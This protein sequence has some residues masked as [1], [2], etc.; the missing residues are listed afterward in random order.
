MK[1]LIV[2]GAVILS[3]GLAGTA[4]AAVI[5]WDTISNSS[6]TADACANGVG[7]ACTFTKGTE[8]LTARAYAT[9][10]NAGSGAFEK[11]TITVYSGGIGVKNPDQIGRSY[12]NNENDSPDHAI[13]NDGRDDLVVFEFS[14]SLFDPDSFRIGWRDNDSDIRWWIG[15]ASLGANFDFTG[16][17][18]S[19]LSGL[20][21]SSPGGS[22][23]VAINTTKSVSGD[24]TGRYL[25]FAPS[26]QDTARNSPPDS[27]YDYFKISQITGTL[28]TV[29]VP[30]PDPDP[31]STVPEPGTAALIGIALA[32]F[33]ANRRRKG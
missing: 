16:Q 20:G 4:A 31:Q 15:G 26:L 10:N 14:N 17:T 28:G 9:N 13:D 25:I 11:A 19:S 22:N 5:T 2:G 7:N 24:E 27:K 29:V 6:T 23:N 8:I 30:P 1:K 18:F 33:W 12:S 21:F 32:G 3:A